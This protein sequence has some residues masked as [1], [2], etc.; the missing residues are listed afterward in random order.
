[1]GSGRCKGKMEGV[2]SKA[3]IMASPT[4]SHPWIC[5]D[6]R[7]TVSIRLTLWHANTYQ[8]Q[9]SI[10][11]KPEKRMRAERANNAKVESC[12]R[13]STYCITQ[14]HDCPRLVPVLVAVVWALRTHMPLHEAS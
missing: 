12:G 9:S 4:A 3:A 8:K 7:P 2:R 5:C 1:M 10:A 13:Y 14:L 6:C 11:C